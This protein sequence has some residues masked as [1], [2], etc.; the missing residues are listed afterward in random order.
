MPSRRWTP[1]ASRAARRPGCASPG[2]AT[3][4]CWSRSTASAC[5]PIR[6]GASAR[7]PSPSPGR[8]ASRAADRAR[9]A[10]AARRGHHLA[11]SLRPPRLPDD[12]RAEGLERRR[13]SCRSA[14]A[15][16][17]NPG[18]FRGA[19][20]RARLVGA[21]ARRRGSDRLHAGAPRLRARHACSTRT[22]RCGPAARCSAPAPRV[23]LGRH[24][25]VPGDAR[26]RRAPRALRPHDDRGRASTI[27][28]GPTGTSGRSRP[29]RAPDGARPRDDARCT[30]A[31]SAW[32]CTAG[33]SPSSACSPPTSGRGAIVAPRP[34]QSVEPER[35]PP[36]R[37]GG[38][39]CPGA[40]RPS[41]QSSRRRWTEPPQPPL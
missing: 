12:R 31:C 39:S 37:A 19:H 16:T 13:S 30:G 17:S 40:R 22:R 34:G 5:S 36:S 14:S 20:R 9:R 10:A 1:R 21:D 25:A 18:A 32:P 8:S 29:C 11:R 4:R 38:R 33:P 27:A 7:R 26:D 3:R 41:T 28:P 35:R 24:R 2:S 23:L 15:R 6:S